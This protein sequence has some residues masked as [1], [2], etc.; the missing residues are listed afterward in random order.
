MLLLLCEHDRF[1]H[2]Q[3]GCVCMLLRLHQSPAD[4]KKTPMPF[5]LCLLL[6]PGSHCARLV[7][8]THGGL[9]LSHTRI[10]YI[11][12]Y[13]Y[14]KP[15]SQVSDLV[16]SSLAQRGEYSGSC[17]TI[18]G[19]CCLKIASLFELEAVLLDRQ[20]ILSEKHL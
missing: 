16:H 13:I 14:V 6:P 5:V 8:G 18:F 12:I 10:I 19:L 20:M 1:V 7:V 4:R 3:G 15:E 17:C 11:Y 9:C 2:L